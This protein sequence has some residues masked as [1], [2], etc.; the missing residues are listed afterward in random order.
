MPRRAVSPGQSECPFAA[1]AGAD[2]LVRFGH[3]L[4]NEGRLAEAAGCYA[5]TTRL[6]PA[7]ADGWFEHGLALQSLGDLVSAV[8]SFGVGLRLRCSTTQSMCE[9]A[10]PSWGMIVA[11]GSRTRWRAFD[12][13]TRTVY[14]Q[15]IIS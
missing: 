8:Q 9:G 3:A 1:A 13:P 4:Q 5:H 11:S 10:R 12:H 7:F 6:H 15:F 2:E 14:V